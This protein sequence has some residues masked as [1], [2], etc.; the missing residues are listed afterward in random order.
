[1]LVAVVTQA[2]E[3]TTWAEAAGV[4][5]RQ[6]VLPVLLVLSWVQRVAKDKFGLLVV[7]CIMLVAAVVVTETQ[8]PP[9]P[10]H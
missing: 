1:M 2:P 6:L 4:V 10:Q 8:Q 9:Q 5:K 7:P 3:L